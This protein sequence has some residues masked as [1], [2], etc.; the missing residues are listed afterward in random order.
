MVK[1]TLD[2][3]M[4]AMPADWRGRWCTGLCGCMGCANRSGNLSL[5]GYTEEDMINY[6]IINP[7]PP[8][9]LPN[10]SGLEVLESFLQKSK[11]DKNEQST[12][13]D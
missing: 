2:E 4:N 5:Y 10:T 11:G 1:P 8:K 12:S 13:K 6:N 7:L 9:Q 3:L